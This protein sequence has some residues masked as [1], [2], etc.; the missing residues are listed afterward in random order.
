MSSVGCCC[1]HLYHN[2]CIIKWI[3]EAK[4]CP[5]CLR[6]SSVEDI[7][8]LSIE[9]DRVTSLTDRRLDETENQ[10]FEFNQMIEKI[11]DASANNLRI[12]EKLENL[13]TILENQHGEKSVL[14]RFF[15]FKFWQSHGIGVPMNKKLNNC[16]NIFSRV[17]KRAEF[18]YELVITKSQI[19]NPEFELGL[20]T[21]IQ[22][23]YLFFY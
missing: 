3:R 8:C 7:A 22:H 10:H 17:K 20:F 13:K 9:D 14:L 15:A 23:V 21:L 5:K 6:T 11:N 12:N 4:N 19:P 18:E 16:K 2:E 1:G